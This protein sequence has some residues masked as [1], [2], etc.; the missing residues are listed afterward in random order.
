[1]TSA[2]V[3]VPTIPSEAMGTIARRKR[4]QPMSMPPSKRM[5]ISA[6]TPIRSTVW[7]WGRAI[8][9]ATAATRKR[10]G[11]GIGNRAVS[12]CDEQGEQDA[13]RDDEHDQP[14]I[15]QLVHA[16]DANGFLTTPSF[17]A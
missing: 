9:V 3:N 5:M 11:A 4:R 10:A 12:F 17:R 8:G 1:M 14:E 7:I 16:G 2:V 6:T 13:D 15:E